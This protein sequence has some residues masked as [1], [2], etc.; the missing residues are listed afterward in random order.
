MDGG[1]SMLESLY[2][3]RISC[4]VSDLLLVRRG[5]DGAL[6]LHPSAQ[7]KRPTKHLL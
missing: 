4:H 6:E 5:M 3:P 1:A 2:K 7:A